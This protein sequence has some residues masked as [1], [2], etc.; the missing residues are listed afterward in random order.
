M[1][2][3]M[4]LRKKKT[5]VQITLD[6]C[7]FGYLSALPTY[8]SCAENLSSFF[9]LPIFPGGL[10]NWVVDVTGSSSSPQTSCCL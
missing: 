2:L 5:E 9:S 1:F 4:Q 8:P 7:L 10:S 3:K 6:A